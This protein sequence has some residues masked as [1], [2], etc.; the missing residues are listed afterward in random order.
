MVAP[1]RKEAGDFPRG[2]AKKPRSSPAAAVPTVAVTKKKAAGKKPGRKPTTKSAAATADANAETILVHDDKHHDKTFKLAKIYAE[3]KVVLGLVKSIQELDLVVSLPAKQFG[4]VSI[5]EIS[6]AI[7]K[8]IQEYAAGGEDSDNDDSDEDD[9]EKKE[10]KKELPNQKRFK[11]DD[12]D[13]DGDD[14]ENEEDEKELPNLKRYFKLG[15]LVAVKVNQMAVNEKTG[16]KRTELTMQPGQL[17]ASLAATEIKPGMVLQGAIKSEEDHGY[18]VEFG[19]DG[20]SGFLPAHADLTYRV[21]QLGFFELKK[22]E[23]GHVFRLAA[24]PSPA[25]F[26]SGEIESHTAHGMMVQLVAPHDSY[27]GLVPSL[28]VSDITLSNPAKRF[29]VGS[30]HK[31]RVLAK[32]GPKFTLTAKKTLV[33]SDAGVIDSY[34][35]DHVGDFG[36]GTIVNVLDS[37]V[38][39]QFY[40]HVRAFVP[41]SEMSYEFLTSTGEYKKGQPVKCRILYAN[42]DEKKM[43]ASFLA[44]PK[45]KKGDKKAAAEPESVDPASTSA[46]D[47]SKGKKKRE[48]KSEKLLKSFDYDA[49]A[50][51]PVSAIDDL[52]VDM[53]LEGYVY[54]VKDKA[55]V[56]VALSPTVTGRVKIAELSAE[57]V[58]DWQKLVKVG[59]K[60]QCRVL[61]L[62]NNRIELTR[63]PRAKVEV[64]SSEDEDSDDDEDAL[65]DMDVDSDDDEVDSGDDEATA[66]V[67]SLRLK[68]GTDGEDDDDDDSDD[69][70]AG[71]TSASDKSVLGGLN[72]FSWSTS[73][74]DDELSGDDSDDGEDGAG[75]SADAMDVD[76]DSKAAGASSK[77]KAKRDKKKEKEEHEKKIAE[78]QATLLNE[79]QLATDYERLLVGSPNSSFL[80]IKY[81]AFQLKLADVNK[82]RAV[83]E[84]AIQTIHYREEQE[85]LNVWV[86]WLNLENQYGDKASLDALFQRAV[87]YN[88]PQTVHQHLVDIF[89]RSGQHD[90]ARD[91]YEDMTAKFK[92][93]PAVWIRYAQFQFERDQADQAR[94]LLPRALKHLPKAHHIH[95][96]TQMALLEFKVGDVERGRTILE[97]VLANYPKRVD[98]WSVYLDMEIKAREFD[99]AR[100]LFDRIITLKFSAKKIKFFF[101]KYLEFEKKFGNEQ[102]VAYVKQRAVEYVEMLN[103]QAA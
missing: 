20:L 83:A 59:D 47:E 49:L 36:H 1:K 87:Q 91:L 39:V 89:T 11:P 100:R 79:P 14:D 26:D 48:L 13:D 63:K 37:G 73:L 93:V 103:K 78:R 92:D 29:P 4:F 64:S 35:R 28:H 3:G 31:F 32:D 61:S 41:I 24:I 99:A 8:I 6:P 85:K 18:L 65:A 53:D 69:E 2:G 88:D 21:G 97:G 94:T 34:R 43:R 58:K 10:D 81:M 102:R 16:K 44:E 51:K 19:I 90:R 46:A 77:N 70:A 80:W 45:S 50:T 84:R 55:G 68:S 23:A 75:A 54:N 25:S 96:I 62:D 40:Q 71:K 33:N 17:Y 7:S 42:E 22:A 38:V 72:G 67:K 30:K 76:G 57:F 95:T 5:T 101:K 27:R 15:Q 98:L 52:R 86:A 74:S 12:D 9:A 82:A 56:F 66:G 60:V